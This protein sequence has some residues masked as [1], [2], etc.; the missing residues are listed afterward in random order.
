M[1]RKRKSKSNKL[2]LYKVKHEMFCDVKTKDKITQKDSIFFNFYIIQ[3]YQEITH[4][5]YEYE[6]YI[7]H[8]FKQYEYVWTIL[9]WHR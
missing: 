7:V 8:T 2:K 5:T 9:Q 4:N 6:Q 1:D 3:T